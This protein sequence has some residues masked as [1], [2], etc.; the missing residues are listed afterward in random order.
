[1][2]EVELIY[3]SLAHFAT[4]AELVFADV[5]G[6]DI[7]QH[8]GDNVAPGRIGDSHLFK[9]S[10]RHAGCTRDW[11]SMNEGVRAGVESHSVSVETVIGVVEG[12]VEIVHAKQNLVGHARGENGIQ[13]GGVI[14]EVNRRLFEVILQ[15]GTG[16][17]QRQAGTERC[18]LVS[19]PVE[20]TEHQMVL[21]AE[22]MIQFEVAVCAGPD[23]RVGTKKVPCL[24]PEVRLRHGAGPKRVN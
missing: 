21:L 18:D 16:R 6:N 1:M 3:M 7:R 10:D 5:V 2:P 11:L 20:G 4:Q 14:L 19:L 24:E 23:R 9:T 12:L 17:G 13:D 22:I 15:V 8:A